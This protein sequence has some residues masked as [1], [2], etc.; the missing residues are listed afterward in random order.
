MLFLFLA[1]A[2]LCNAFSQESIK[3]L[4]KKEI[5]LGSSVPLSGEVSFLGQEYIKGAR[6]YIKYANEQGIIPQGV[7]KLEVLDDKYIPQDCAQNTLK[8]IKEKKVFAL[9][10]YVGSSTTLYV[11][12]LISSSKVPL[13]GVFSG[14]SSLRKPFNPYVFNIRPSLYTE[15]S[16][17]I[18]HCL[19]D[20]G[21]KKIAVFYQFDAL[22]SDGLSAAEDALFKYSNYTL[23]LVA[24]ESYERLSLK[25]EDAVDKIKASGA[26]AVILVGTYKPVGKFIKLC[27]KKDYSP[28]FYAVSSVGIEFLIGELKEEA[29]GIVISSVVP[30]LE[31]DSLTAVR[32]Y[33]ELLSKYFPDGTPTSVGFEG[34][35]NAKVLVEG[36]KRMKE[37]DTD[38][39]IRSLE[40][41]NSFDIG[42]EESISFGMNDH[43]GLKKIYFMWV[44]DGALTSLRDWSKIKMFLGDS[45]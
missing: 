4:I 40:N 38:G 17:F 32:E 22:G 37:D 34:F 30:P 13:V 26:E 27:H 19:D 15:I 42:I 1:G 24:K 43:E 8:L 10:S 31:Q 14:V 29:T 45:K 21:I 5:F 25:V 39:F 2:V 11:L 18:K 20:L 28:L 41:L 36:L 7:V 12:P 35:L 6:V 44:E 23:N 33:K 3:P 16:Q 9:F